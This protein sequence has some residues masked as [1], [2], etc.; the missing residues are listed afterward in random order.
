MNETRIISILGYVH[1]MHVAHWQQ[2]FVQIIFFNILNVCLIINM[3]K[4]YTLIRYK[5]LLYFSLHSTKLRNCDHLNF[6]GQLGLRGCPFLPFESIHFIG[7]S[8][9]WNKKGESI[10]RKEKLDT[11]HLHVM[12]MLDNVGTYLS[13]AR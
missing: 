2:V 13:L 12:L 4:K 5:I 6:L 1:S 9:W 8:T 7:V 3:P 11:A 10:E